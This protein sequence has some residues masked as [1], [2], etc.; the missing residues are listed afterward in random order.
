MFCSR[1]L[2]LRDKQARPEAEPRTGAQLQ[3]EVQRPGGIRPWR[4]EAQA[5]PGLLPQQQQQQQQNTLLTADPSRGLQ[6]KRTEL[7][8]QKVLLNFG[9]QQWPY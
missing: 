5:G 1:H 9:R 3:E 8:R 7:L 2:E 4:S 6:L